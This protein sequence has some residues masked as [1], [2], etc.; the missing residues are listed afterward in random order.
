MTGSSPACTVPK[1]D[2]SPWPGVFLVRLGRSSVIV[3][4]STEDATTP[5][6]GVV[7]QG[8]GGGVVQWWALAETLVRSLKWR[9]HSKVVMGKP[10]RV[11]AIRGHGEIM[12]DG[13]HP[14]ETALRK[15]HRPGRGRSAPSTRRGVVAFLYEPRAMHAQLV[16]ADERTA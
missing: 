7:E 13:G 15:H 6:R 3:D 12:G 9:M 16:A 5:D 11:V 1:L 8:H 4:H 2:A 10:P 14:A